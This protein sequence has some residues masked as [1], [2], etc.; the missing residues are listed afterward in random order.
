MNKLTAAILALLVLLAAGLGYYSYTLNRQLDDLSGQLTSLATEQSAAG[1]EIA[2]LRQETTG[3]LSGLRQETAD[4]LAGLEAQLGETQAGL[5]TLDAALEA[6]RAELARLGDQVAGISDFSASAVYQQVSRVTVRITDGESTVASGVIWDTAGHVVTAYHVIDGLSPIYVVTAD[7]LV[8]RASVTGSCLYS[9]IAVIQLDNNPGIAP[10]PVADSSVVAIGAPV[11]AVGNPFNLPGTLTAGIVS[12]V[13]RFEEIDYTT[14]SRSVA[15]LIQ[16]DAP[17]NPGNSGCPLVNAAGELLGI[18]I[19]RIDATEGDGIYYAVAANKVKRVAEAIIASGSFAYP[20][21]G[22]SAG[23]LTPDL[24]EARGLA[25][26]NGVLVADVFPGDPAQVA[27]LRVD[28]IIVSLDGV[29]VRD[30]AGL[31][32]YLGELKGP[33]DTCRL[34]ILRDGQSL[35]LDAVLTVRTS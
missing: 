12:Q 32:A 29:P 1:Q 28:D 25:S 13:D 5:D 17:V 16:F 10:L 35:S 33:G 11:V 30:T 34:G 7:G 3:V 2:D 18:V 15:N 22:V 19:A 4:A 20:W 14:E 21:L 8:S 23:D 6:G 26:A 31:T 24:V 27:G 9:D